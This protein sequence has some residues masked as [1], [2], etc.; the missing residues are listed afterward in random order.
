MAFVHKQTCTRAKHST[1]LNVSTDVF[2]IATNGTEY[3]SPNQHGR[4]FGTIYRQYVSLPSIATDATV[5]IS[6][7]ASNLQ[8]IID[9][10][11]VAH[12]SNG[13]AFKIPYSDEN[14]NQGGIEGYIDKSPFRITIMNG[15]N[16]S[17]TGGHAWVDYTKSA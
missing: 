6:I 8:N 14:E 12:D 7:T 11:I 4:L 15:E 9:Y 2:E 10:N 13:D 1:L 3:I 17:I 16:I 5:N